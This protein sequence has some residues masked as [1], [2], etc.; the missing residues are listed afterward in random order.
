MGKIDVNW[1]ELVETLK[2]A[3]MFSVQQKNVDYM[4]KRAI[5]KKKL[6]WILKVGRIAACRG[7][8]T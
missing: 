3:L 4:T 2:M 5:N 7:V 8:F 6:Y 1:V